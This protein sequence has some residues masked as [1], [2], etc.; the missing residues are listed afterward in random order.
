MPAKRIASQSA[1]ESDWPRSSP[2][3]SKSESPVPQLSRAM[4]LRSFLVVFWLFVVTCSLAADI[5]DAEGR[6]ITH[7][8]YF[9]MRIGDEDIGRIEFGLYG[10][11][12]PRTVVSSIGV[13][14][15]LPRLIIFEHWLL[16][17]AFLVAVDL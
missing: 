16:V 6:V 11:I 3:L 5:T 4:S 9:D 7:R 15:T 13:M 17:R 2:A 1:D 10:Q 8:V 14:L 12:V